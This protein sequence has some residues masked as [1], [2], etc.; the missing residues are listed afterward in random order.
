MSMARH[1]GIRAWSENVRDSVLTI[2][3]SESLCE[4]LEIPTSL[5]FHLPPQKFDEIVSGFRR[6]VA[7]EQRDIDGPIERQAH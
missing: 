4:S 3:F 7:A 5:R 6:I 1:S 2:D